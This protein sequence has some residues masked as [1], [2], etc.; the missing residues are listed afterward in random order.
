VVTWLGGAPLDAWD[1]DR[2]RLGFA[3]LLS[4]DRTPTSA[5]TAGVAVLRPGERLEPHRHEPAEVYLILEGSVELTLGEA[6]H[7]LDEGAVAFIPG[8][9]THGVRALGDVTARVFY[10]LACDSFDDMQYDF[11]P[12]SSGEP[13]STADSELEPSTRSS[14]SEV[15]P[16]ASLTASGG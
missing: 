6:V 2:G 10:V 9:V 16:A 12:A 7:E 8:N 3:S 15:S 5:M 11:S 1:D 4:A 14:V 13:A